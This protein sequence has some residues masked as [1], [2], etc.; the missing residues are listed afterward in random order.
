MNAFGYNMQ[1][2][3]VRVLEVNSIEHHCVRERLVCTTELLGVKKIKILLGTNTSRNIFSPHNVALIFYRISNWVSGSKR[4]L[5]Q[6]ANM[7]NRNCT[8]RLLF[9]H[10]ASLHIQLQIT[11]EYSL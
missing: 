3:G 8:I 10:R 1:N 6:H 7:Q 4:K 5:Y 11:N 9:K 2:T